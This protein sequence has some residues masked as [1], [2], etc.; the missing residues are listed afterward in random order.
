MLI[1]KEQMPT[2]K[3][4]PIN[5]SKLHQLWTVIDETQTNILL[6][7]S[8]TELIQQLLRQLE[9]RGLVSYEEVSTIS[10]YIGSRVPLIRDLARARMAV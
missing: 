10:A 3:L 6:G 8:D 1:N 2:A 7:F 4:S 5:S 9:G